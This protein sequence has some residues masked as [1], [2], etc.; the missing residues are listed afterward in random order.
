MEAKTKAYIGTHN[1][2]K[3]G[4]ELFAPANPNRKA[5]AKLAQRKLQHA[6]DPVKG[7]NSPK[8]PGS[9]NRRNG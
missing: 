7:V 9:L 5:Q 4:K 3:A 1:G 6:K 8:A 2:V